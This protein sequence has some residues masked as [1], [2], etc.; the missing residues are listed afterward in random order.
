M[1]GKLQPMVIDQPWKRI[2]LDLMG[3]LPK[4][5]QGFRYI[6]VIVD[7][8]SKWVETFPLKTKSSQEIMKNFTEH[9]VSRFGVP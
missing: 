9:V 5:E 1:V 2:G 8:F 7:Y 4:M 3:P 6:M